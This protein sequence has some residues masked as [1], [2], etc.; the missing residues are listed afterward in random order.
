MR[1]WQINVCSCQRIGGKSSR[2]VFANSLKI[3]TRGGGVEHNSG[4]RGQVVQAEEHCVLCKRGGGSLGIPP[5]VQ[6]CPPIVHEQM[7]VY[8]QFIYIC[9]IYIILILILI[10]I[11]KYIVQITI[12]CE[13]CTDSS[14]RGSKEFVFDALTVLRGSEWY[15]SVD[16]MQR[17]TCWVICGD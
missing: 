1:I 14:R 9:T 15:N 16:Y 17:V 5:T 2:S 11:I 4:N 12:S 3:P 7:I 10:L 8:I 6:L 13:T